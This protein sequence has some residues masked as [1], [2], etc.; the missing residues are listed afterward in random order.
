LLWQAPSPADPG[1]LE[2]QSDRQQKSMAS[3]IVE[4]AEIEGG[5]SVIGLIII[6]ELCEK[7]YYVPQL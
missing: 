5:Q 2:A 3:P 4:L 6:E 7:T 1:V